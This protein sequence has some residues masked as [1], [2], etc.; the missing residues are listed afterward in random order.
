M[1]LGSSCFKLFIKNKIEVRG[2]YNSTVPSVNKELMYKVDITDVNQVSLFV[3]KIDAEL[4]DVILINCAGSNY[5]AFAHKADP[6]KWARLIQINLVGTFNIINALL[7]VMRE[8]NFGRI[9][10]MA[11]VV[12]QK[13]VAGTS[14]YAASKSGL[15][16]MSKAI[17]AENASK[18]IT[19][20]NLNLGYFQIGMID[21]VPGDL[22]EKIKTTIPKRDFGNPQD[23][24][25]SINYLMDTD[26]ITGTS[27]DL[28][29]GLY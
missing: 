23:I 22:Q 25:N 15:W 21:D 14:A 7:P 11:S 29:G 16:G 5:N 6:V 18:G 17:A 13:G 12:A 3:E 9:I 19:I 4:K 8:Q 27:I 24:L 26:Y 20:N 2:I 28:N 10:N 1:D